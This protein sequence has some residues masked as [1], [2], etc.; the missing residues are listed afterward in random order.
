MLN[1]VCN[2]IICL[3]ITGTFSLAGAA[4]VSL[5]FR[6]SVMINDTL[7]KLGDIAEIRCTDD[8]WSGILQDF[9]V[10]DAA[11]AGHSR[12]ICRDDLITYKMQ[13]QL[14]SVQLIARGAVRTCI[15]TNYKEL[16]VGNFN[17]AIMQYINTAISWPAG[18]WYLSV[19]N[20]TDKIKI[21]DKPYRLEFNGIT[22][23]RPKG[24]FSFQMSIIQGGTVIRGPVRCA[25]K[26]SLPVI[27]AAS[28]IM[29]GEIITPDKCVFKTIDITHYG[30][31]P[32]DNL[33]QV[34]GKRAV[35]QIQAGN[36][37]TN[38]WLQELPVVEKGDAIRIISSINKVKVAVDAVA[39]ES[40]AIGEKIWAENAASHKMVRVVIKSKGHA[41]L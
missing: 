26:I 34:V 1:V 40:G 24:Q 15:T 18:S 41:E 17:D 39:R 4:Q 21:L 32:C 35:R 3:L 23:N 6:D 9:V 5:M 38:K 2:H 29:R 31:T 19:L 10:G 13:A 16:I 33:S 30:I 28:P 20:T 22:N 7:I 36:V 27:L 25:M 8:S 14:K 37:L 12:F 11:P